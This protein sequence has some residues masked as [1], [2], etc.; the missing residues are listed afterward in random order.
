MNVGINEAGMGG[1]S[2]A[3]QSGSGAT[4]GAVELDTLD[5]TLLSLFAGWAA[6][7]DIRQRLESKGFEGIRFSDGLIFQHL[8]G[9]DRTITELAARMEVTQQAASKA[10]ADLQRRGWV[11]LNVDPADA[12]ARRVALSERG[13]AAVEASR[14]VRA[15]LVADLTAECGTADLTAARRVLSVMIGRVGGDIA[16]RSRRVMPPA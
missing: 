13:L 1:S 5:V 8:V 12:R 3:G 10:V 11:A 6:A 9:A 2:G 4:S 16:V 7:D 15:E 14:A